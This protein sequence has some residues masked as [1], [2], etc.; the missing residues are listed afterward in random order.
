MVRRMAVGTSGGG[1]ELVSGIEK[2]VTQEFGQQLECAVS[3]GVS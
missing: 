2:S 1:G 3:V